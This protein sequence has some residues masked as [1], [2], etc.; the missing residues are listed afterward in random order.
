MHV[1][2]CGKTYGKSVDAIE[3]SLNRPSCNKV[4]RQARVVAGWP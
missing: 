1:R 2:M 4:L 3:I